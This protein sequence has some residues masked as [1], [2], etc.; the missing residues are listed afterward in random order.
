MLF[1]LNGFGARH[2][3]GKIDRP[4]MII[5][6]RIRAVDVTQ[7]ALKAEV[8]NGRDILGLELLDINLGVFFISTIAINGFKQ[9]GKAAAKFVAQTTICTQAKDAFH[10]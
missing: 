5:A 6:W 3:A 10:F 9:L 2:Q 1:D 8:H 4:L 7:L